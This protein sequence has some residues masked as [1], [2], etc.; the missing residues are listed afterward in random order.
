MHHPHGKF[1]ALLSSEIDYANIAESRI[2]VV[3]PTLRKLLNWQRPQ[4]LL[5][6]GGG[7]GLFLRR[8]IPKATVRAIHY[9][10][11]PNMRALAQQRLE[12]GDR[13]SV[14]TT[15]KSIAPD[16]I[17]AVTMT[18]VWM[19]FP[20]RGAAVSNLNEI[21]R[22]LSLEG[23]LYAAVTHPCFREEKFSTFRTDFTNENYL[24]AGEPYTVTVTDGKNQASFRDYHWN[25]EAMSSQLYAAGFAI[26][27]L[28]E[29]GD[30]PA[31]HTTPL[32]GSPWL[33]FEAQRWRK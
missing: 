29:T 11:S 20:H 10:A 23:R 9:D 19:E 28:Y 31:T 14:V 18:A 16:S 24:Q 7:D 4:V 3:F 21:A 25:L 32:R 17:D 1:G 27:R 12:G 33:I 22:I 6:Y 13:Y 15:T 8:Y 26:L 2:A 30:A 5:D